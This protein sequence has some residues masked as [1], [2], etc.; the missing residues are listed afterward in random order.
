MRT[1]LATK[2]GIQ[3]WWSV[4]N[5]N[6]IYRIAMVPV[7]QSMYATLETHCILEF[8]LISIFIRR[9]PWYLNIVRVP[10][11]PEENHQ[12]MKSSDRVF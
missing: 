10:A 11:I 3:V 1:P 12:V 7:S 9:V 4:L 5:R 2:D 6:P 8:L